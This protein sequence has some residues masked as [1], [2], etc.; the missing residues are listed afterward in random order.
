MRRPRLAILLGMPLRKA[1]A[2]WARVAPETVV[3]YDGEPD[4]PY[5]IV[6]RVTVNEPATDRSENFTKLEQNLQRRVAKC[7]GNAAITV[8]RQVSWEAVPKWVDNDP[9]RTI[10]AVAVRIVD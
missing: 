5:E 10:S 2:S 8:R 3:L 6:R 9:R 1:D 7:R 4:R